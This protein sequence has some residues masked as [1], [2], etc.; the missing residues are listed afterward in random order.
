MIKKG[1]SGACFHGCSMS[2]E[3]VIYDEIP[4][5]EIFCQNS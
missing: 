1:L 2:P 3:I 4:N 5:L